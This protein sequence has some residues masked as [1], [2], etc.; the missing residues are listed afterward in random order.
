MP[1]D[2]THA[3]LCCQIWEEDKAISEYVNR[4]FDIDLDG[5]ISEAELYHFGSLACGDDDEAIEEM[6]EMMRG[7]SAEGMSVEDFIA[8]PLTQFE[9]S[10]KDAIDAI[11]ATLGLQVEQDV[12]L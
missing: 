2:T 8:G 4:C 7:M 12:C 5:T 9:M 11:N 6:V 3:L 10:P 1:S